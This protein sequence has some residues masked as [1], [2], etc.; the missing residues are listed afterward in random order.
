SPASL[1]AINPTIALSNRIM[2]VGVD[3]ISVEEA[4]KRSQSSTS[5]LGNSA[6]YSNAAKSVPAPTN[7][8]AY[9]DLPVLYSRIDS[10][11]RPMLFLGAAFLPWLNDYVDLTKLPPAEIVTKHLSP[12]VS[13]QL[14]D[15]NGYVAESLG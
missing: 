13:S 9:V 7:F 3:P 10:T 8:F 12:V 14:Y 5:E 1:F 4:I 6:A 15:R 11:V 2:I